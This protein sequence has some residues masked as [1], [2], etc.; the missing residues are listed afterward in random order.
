MKKCIPIRNP[1]WLTWDA[2]PAGSDTRQL[3]SQITRIT[4]T[5]AFL[6]GRFRR[7]CTTAQYLQM[8]PLWATPS[9]SSLEVKNSWLSTVPAEMS[10][11]FALSFELLFFSTAL[12]RSWDKNV[13]CSPIFLKCY[14]IRLYWRFIAKHAPSSDQHP[15]SHQSEQ[16]P[17]RAQTSALSSFPLLLRVTAAWSRAWG[18]FVRTAK[19]GEGEGG[20]EEGEYRCLH[21]FS[22]SLLSAVSPQGIEMD[23]Q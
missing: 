22:P 8:G 4:A 15:A 19:G 23:I 13:K 2:S 21:P 10:S 16:I 18:W 11:F 17:S 5:V 3:I 14:F 6:P 1:K 9:P 20:R 7:G 12:G